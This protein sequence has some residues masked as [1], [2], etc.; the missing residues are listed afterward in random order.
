MN[1][2]WD[3][4]GR[5]L[6]PDSLCPSSVPGPDCGPFLHASKAMLQ[7]L[8]ESLPRGVEDIYNSKWELN[9]DWDILKTDMRCPSYSSLKKPKKLLI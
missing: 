7:N 3:E 2:L 9:L 4:L 1:E 5:R 8:V 6:E